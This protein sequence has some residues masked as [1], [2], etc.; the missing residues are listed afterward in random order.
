MLGEDQN[1]KNLSV[2]Q[3]LSLGKVDLFY[4]NTPFIISVSNFFNSFCEISHMPDF[5]VPFHPRHYDTSPEGVS[6]V[7]SY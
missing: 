6:N 3:L 5:C 7:Q 2:T 1:H 4:A